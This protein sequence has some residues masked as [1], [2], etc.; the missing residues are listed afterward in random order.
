MTA[1]VRNRLLVIGALWSLLLAAVPALVMTDPYRL[2]GFLIAALGCAV[3]S[4]CVGTL[5]AGRRAARRVGRSGFVDGVGTGIAQGLV[6]G[7]IAA[8]LFWGLMALTIS[9]FTLRN[10]VD[11][12]VLMSPRVFIGSFFVALS[13]FVYAL[14]GGLL[15]G[16]VFGRLVNRTVRS[17][18]EDKSTDEREDLVVR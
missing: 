8:L 12:S 18:K 14:I 16:P 13:A 10:P 9:G 7:G 17:N 2:T 4:G 6:G 5:A 15:L 3:L 1:P 11:V